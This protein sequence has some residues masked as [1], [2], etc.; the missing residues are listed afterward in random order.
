M[1]TDVNDTSNLRQNYSTIYTTEYIDL[2]RFSL[3]LMLT[4]P[5]ALVKTQDP[6]A[7]YAEIAAALAPGQRYVQEFDYQ[8]T[9]MPTSTEQRY[10]EEMYPSST[11]S[12]RDNDYDSW[13]VAQGGLG[14]CGTFANIAC[15]A[16]I[17]QSSPRA[18][19]KGICPMTPSPIG[20]YFV[21]VADPDVPTQTV[22]IAIDS[23]VPCKPGGKS[24]CIFVSDGQP[25]A[26]ALLMKAAA[27]VRGGSINEITNSATLKRGFLGW[28]PQVPKTCT[29]FDEF[30]DAI[31]AD[32]I[33]V[34]SMTQ[35]YDASG[36]KITPSGVVLGHAFGAVECVE[37]PDYQ[38][39]RVE[40]PWQSG[41]DFVSEYSDDSAWW[42]GHPELTE[43]K[44]HS[45]ASKG[46]YW[47]SWDAF[48]KLTGKSSFNVKV[49]A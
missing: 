24:S 6:V 22:W 10:L 47:V 26:A 44:S 43:L 13:E 16:S 23:K 21:K 11:I 41:S 48:K 2:H 7:T 39:I 40:N 32:G 17:P 30:K 15:Y 28:F 19:E 8:I 49:P 5:I 36:A 20:L 33:Y 46:N 34:F 35:Q 45:I 25:L 1:I 29:T 38:L 27:T 37:G 18:L 14:A 31:D 42:D 12:G 9:E 3:P 4:Q